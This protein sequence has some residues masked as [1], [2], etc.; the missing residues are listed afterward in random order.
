MYP[1]Q[2]DVQVEN[3]VAPLRVLVK[4]WWKVL[5]LPGWS[6][7]AT[8]Q[9]GG[10]SLLG[11][12]TSQHIIMSMTCSGC[13][14]RWYHLQTDE[15]CLHMGP[16]QVNLTAIQASCD[17]AKQ[18]GEGTRLPRCWNSRT[19]Q[20]FCA[21]P[22]PRT[23]DERPNRNNGRSRM[24]QDPLLALR[25]LHKH[26]PSLRPILPMAQKRRRSLVNVSAQSHS[27]PTPRF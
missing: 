4:T 26:H 3:Y 18:S 5:R 19:L 7:T 22:I 20:H 12:W 15:D 24:A 23:T 11:V 10:L 2:T 27:L 21:N 9:I 25:T 16:V 8:A 1:G 6:N 14:Q 13:K 17:V